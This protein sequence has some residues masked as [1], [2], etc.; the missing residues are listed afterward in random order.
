M[1]GCSTKSD[2]ISTEFALVKSEVID[3]HDVAMAK[4]GDMISLKKQLIAKLDSNALDSSYVMAIQDLEMAD[5]EMMT[6]MRGFSNAFTSDQLA[7]GLS[8]TF[9]TEEEKLE[10]EKAL[11]TINIQKKLAVDMQQH[12]DNAVSNAQVLLSNMTTNE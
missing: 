7:N 6:W 12:I 11:G 9:D 3:I 8:P 1:A 5:H 4:M 10:A 2:P